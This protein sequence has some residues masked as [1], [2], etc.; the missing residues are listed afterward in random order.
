MERN[1]HLSD[2]LKAYQRV[3]NKNL[4]GFS[5]E[6][7]ITRSTVQ[8][9]MVDGNTTVDTLVRMA[10]ALHVSLDELV[11]GEL[12]TKRL[13]DVQHFLNDVGW[14]VKLSPEKQESFRYHLE[15][16]LKLLEYDS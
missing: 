7:G 15:T 3:R 4:A 13:D 14:F 6:L 8:S 16:L 9:I 10:N 12:P 11:F 5:V 2:N 1:N